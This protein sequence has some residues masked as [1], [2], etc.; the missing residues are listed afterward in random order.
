VKQ[1]DDDRVVLSLVRRPSILKPMFR[2]SKF[3]SKILYIRKL[4]NSN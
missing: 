1:V 2:H 3:C 4:V